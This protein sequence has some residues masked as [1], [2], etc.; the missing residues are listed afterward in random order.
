MTEI[1]FLLIEGTFGAPAVLLLGW[2]VIRL[3][4]MLPP[5]LKAYRVRATLALSLVLI[6]SLGALGYALYSFQTFIDC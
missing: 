3:G 6:C 5:L 4:R 1:W 2:L